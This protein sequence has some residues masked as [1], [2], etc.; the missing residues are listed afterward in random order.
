M[1]A[2]VNSTGIGKSIKWASPACSFKIRANESVKCLERLEKKNDRHKNNHVECATH[3]LTNGKYDT[4]WYIFLLKLFWI[5]IRN[6]SKN[7]ITC[8]VA[9]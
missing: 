8:I 7:N 2:A 3:F 5:R 4:L 9:S 6:F 1:I